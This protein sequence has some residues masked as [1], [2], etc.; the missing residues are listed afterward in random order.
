[1]RI[2]Y[3]YENYKPHFITIKNKHHELHSFIVDHGA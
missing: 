2:I 1:M 3:K